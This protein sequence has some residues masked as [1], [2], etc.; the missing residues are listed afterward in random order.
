MSLPVKLKEERFLGLPK[1]TFAKILGDDYV[2]NGNNVE[3]IKFKTVS[4]SGAIVNYKQ[5]CN[6]NNGIS[7]SDEFKISFPYKKYFI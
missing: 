5:T 4:P 6:V 7:S 3:T 2:H 1:D